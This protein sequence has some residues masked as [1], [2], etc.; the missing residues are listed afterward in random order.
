MS[1]EVAPG[2]DP[3]KQSR[4]AAGIPVVPVFDGYRAYAI[5]SVVLLHLIVFSGGVQA[6]GSDSNLFGHVVTATLGQAIDVL[7]VISGFVVFLPTVARNGDFGGI[8]AYFIRRIARLGPAYWLI[9]LIGLALVA[10]VSGSP[11][12]DV[13]GVGNFIAHALFLQAPAQMVEPIPTGFGVNGAIW[14]LSLEITFYLLLP[15]VAGWYTRRPILGLVLAAALTAAWHEGFTHLD[16]VYSFFS[17]EA[18]EE[19]R[20]QLQVASAAQFPFFAFSFAAGMTGAWAYVR[21]IRP[22]AKPMVERYVIPVLVVSLA[23]LALFAYLLGSAP[24]ADFSPQAARQSPF[25]A[26]GYPG[27][28]AAA[29]VAGALAPM[30]WQRIFG[31]RPA[32]WLGDISYGIYLVHVLIVTFA[33][34]ALREEPTDGVPGLNIASLVGDG[35]VAYLLKLTVIVVPLSVA[36]GWASAR[37][38]EQPI[39]RWAR[40]YGRRGEKAAA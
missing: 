37:F 15:L 9:L 22:D 36:Y 11:P 35:S 28:L 13:P 1:T 17:I 31:N 8:S 33:V 5:A 19:S 7:F 2:G 38:V 40:R 16:S 14:T 27:F 21:L 25:I 6:L 29:M 23:G 26:I 24:G 18:S 30:G 32:R 39:R 12:L 4:A 34:R 20:V 10:F 3:G